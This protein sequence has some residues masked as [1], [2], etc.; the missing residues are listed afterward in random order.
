MTVQQRKHDIWV[1]LLLLVLVLAS[2][3]GVIV[4]SYQA[5]QLFSDV[6][7]QRKTS[8]NLEEE[9]GR[10]LLEESTWGSHSRVEA[11]AIARLAMKAP[12]TASTVVV[13]QP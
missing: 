9:W 12:D 7:Q 10:L 4:S 1:S 6:Q 3:L 13:K 11:L 2:A 8:H 5:R